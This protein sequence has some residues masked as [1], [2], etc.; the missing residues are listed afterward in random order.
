MNG[1]LLEKVNQLVEQYPDSALL[2]LD[3]INTNLLSEVQHYDFVLLQVQA[4]DKSY[5]DITSET[6]IFQAIDYFVNRK[7]FKK[8]A[9]AYYYAGRV[10]QKRN[11]DEK[12]MIAFMDAL[13]YVEDNEYHLTGLIQNNIGHLLYDQMYLTEA[14]DWFRKAYN[15]F[16]NERNSSSMYYFTTNSLISLGNVLA[17]TGDI[18]SAIFNYRKAL[19]IARAN[20]DTILQ[21]GTIQNIG[22]TYYTAQEYG[23][24]KSEY[25]Q[26]IKLTRTGHES[27]LLYLS[28]IQTYLSENKMDSASYYKKIL[29]RNI[30]DIKDTATLFAVFQSFATIEEQSGN[31]QTALHYLKK[32]VECIENLYDDH[33]SQVTYEVQKRYDFEIVLEDKHRLLIEK[34]NRNRFIFGLIVSL[35]MTIL[36]SFYLHMKKIKGQKDMMEAIQK[37]EQVK[38]LAEEEL[39][40][41]EKVKSNIE[42][43]LE[44]SKE[45][46]Q[47]N[48]RRLLAEY[49]DMNAK[50]K[51]LSSVSKVDLTQINAII[52]DQSGKIDCILLARLAPELFGVIEELEKRNDERLSDSEKKICCMYYYGFDALEINT[53]FDFS[54]N[55]IYTKTTNIRK[56]LRLDKGGD[57]KKFLDQL[58]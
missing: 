28:M 44:K 43:K 4:K 53:Y 1:Q 23:K 18:D 15:S 26:A 27:A 39:A 55:T 12:S 16:K 45:L 25:S 17:L 46:Q 8:A 22:Y 51:K 52:Y 49:F 19:D 40:H 47:E 21:I 41:I 3:S 36:F 54:I 48:F 35:L 5:Q 20:K 2:L 50:L 34:Q 37:K 32:Q 10:H 57:I 11:A 30:N 13:K 6:E 58:M 33:I 42:M 29:D 31:C 7:D 56:K 9:L 24:S 38:K 14:A